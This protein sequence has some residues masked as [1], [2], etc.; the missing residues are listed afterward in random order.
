MAA[1]R[2]GAPVAVAAGAGDRIR[3]RLNRRF[4]SARQWVMSRLTRTATAFTAPAYAR[5]ETIALDVGGSAHQ[6]EPP[7]SS[8][9][10]VASKLVRMLPS[11]SAPGAR[12]IRL[13]AGAALAIVAVVLTGC[14]SDTSDWPARTRSYAVTADLDAQG[15]L[16]V[17][18][19]IVYDFRSS[20]GH[21]ITREIPTRPADQG[22]VFVENVS[23]SSPSGAPAHARVRRTDSTTTIRIGEPDQV[24]SGS[25]TYVL[26]YTLGGVTARR[27]DDAH[28]AWDAIGTGW[29]TPIDRA[30]VRLTAPAKP[31]GVLCYVGEEGSHRRCV[32]DQ[33][34]G[35]TLTVAQSGLAAKNGVTIEADLPGSAVTADPLTADRKRVAALDAR[36]P[37]E[38]EHP[39]DSSKLTWGLIMGGALVAV[40]AIG[41]AARGGGRGG[42][43]GG[44]FGYGYGLGGHGGGFG[45]GGG[46]GAGGGGGGGGGGGW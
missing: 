23:A 29:R 44:G 5:A 39:S 30:R 42:G 12:R 34:G 45:G 18:E 40:V 21:G 46:G 11:P 27:G 36:K 15:R 13:A 8:V 1:A 26:R 35:T 22:G 17:T 37:A 25:N 9:M 2:V 28:V 24:V 31:S 4:R 14:S 7:G 41:L 33:T 3:S 32:A 38:I 43:G 20:D 19:T 10:A 16:A 6:P